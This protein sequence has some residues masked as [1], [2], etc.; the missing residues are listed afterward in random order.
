[1]IHI[2]PSTEYGIAILLGV[3]STIAFP[4]VERID[5]SSKFNPKETK[6]LKTNQMT[7]LLP[8]FSSFVNQTYHKCSRLEILLPLLKVE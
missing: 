6:E 8:F 4:F 1:M 3:G 7:E 5:F 2:T